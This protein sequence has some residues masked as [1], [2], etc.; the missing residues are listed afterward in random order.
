M[1]DIGTCI[2]CRFRSEDGECLEEAPQSIIRNKNIID[3]AH[4]GK[5]EPVYMKVDS[6]RKA[7]GKGKPIPA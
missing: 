2:E 6:D 4:N 7:C 3:H 5:Q 1:A